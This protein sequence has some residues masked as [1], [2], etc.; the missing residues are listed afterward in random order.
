M[1]DSFHFDRIL[2][3]G[4]AISSGFASVYTEKVIKS[5]RRKQIKKSLAHVQAQLAVVSL[6]I[7]GFY[8]AY[9]DTAIII[10]KVS[11]SFIFLWLDFAT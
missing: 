7:L 10:E 9:K 6:L 4:I 2:L 5:T 8:T 3:T 1:H 11:K